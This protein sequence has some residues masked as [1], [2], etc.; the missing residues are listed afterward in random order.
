MMV[1]IEDD[2]SRFK[3]RV[4]VDVAADVLLA[5]PGRGGGCIGVCFGFELRADADRA[6][7]GV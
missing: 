3:V 7:V 2:L 4:G 6:S 1:E 5:A